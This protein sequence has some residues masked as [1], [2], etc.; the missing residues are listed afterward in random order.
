MHA[1]CQAVP[2]AVF[3][4]FQWL[5]LSGAGWKVSEIPTL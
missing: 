4:W 2:I 3:C 5:T 1:A